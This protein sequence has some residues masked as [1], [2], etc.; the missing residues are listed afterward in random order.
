MPSKFAG[1]KVSELKEELKSRGLAVTGLKAELLARLLAAE[2]AVSEPPSKRPKAAVVEAVVE[3]APAVV[4]T[5]FHSMENLQDK[6]QALLSSLGGDSDQ[7]RESALTYLHRTLLPLAHPEEPAS[8]LLLLE[9]LWWDVGKLGSRSERVGKF[10][11]V[12]FEETGQLPSRGSLDIPLA[13]TSKFHLGLFKRETKVHDVRLLTRSVEC[14]LHPQQ[15]VLGLSQHPLAL[16]EWLFTPRKFAS[17]E[18]LKQRLGLL[19]RLELLYPTTNRKRVF[20]THPASASAYLSPQGQVQ[21]TSSGGNLAPLT[22]SNDVLLAWQLAALQTT[23]DSIP[24]SEL[25]SGVAVV[26]GDVDA[27]V[28]AC[29]VTKQVFVETSDERIVAN[30][31]Q[32]LLAKAPDSRVLLI[33]AHSSNRAVRLARST[34]PKLSALDVISLDRDGNVFSPPTAV[35]RFGRQRDKFY[36]HHLASLPPPAVGGVEVLKLQFPDCESIDPALDFAHWEL[37]SSQAHRVEFLVNHRARLVV[38][39]PKLDPQRQFAHGSFDFVVLDGF[40]TQTHLLV[41]GSVVK[42]TR[43]LVCLAGEPPQFAFARH[44]KLPRQPD[45]VATHSAGFA[46]PTQRVQCRAGR[47]QAKFA[48]RVC[49]FAKKIGYDS[50]V[51]V[52]HTEQQ[53][54]WVDDECE[55]NVVLV[56]PNM[57]MPL[58]QVVVECESDLDT[59]FPGALAVVRLRETGGAGLR[60]VLGERFGEAFDEELRAGSLHSVSTPGQLQDTLPHL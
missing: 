53:G 20:S 32:Q 36:Q 22:S 15:L 7:T 17:L 59:D 35:E 2:D 29:L 6:F 38:T 5:N 56:R 33:S 48:A 26:A 3:A 47:D 55:A 27:V 31:L 23:V 10:H 49:E 52:V 39:G 34:L 41:Y 21:A 16:P 28:D 51:V 24:F 12:C 45:V 60:L 58:A 9:M 54:Q 57:T 43:S 19:L 42:P 40:H 8:A 13:L 1:L 25:A 30:V 44:L 18:H 50:A 11:Q 46:E 37:F 14:F 4:E